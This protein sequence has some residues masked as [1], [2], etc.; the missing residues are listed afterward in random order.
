MDA[1]ACCE[2]SKVLQDGSKCRLVL[3]LD[4]LGRTSLHRDGCIRS[5]HA[6]LSTSVRLHLDKLSELAAL[7]CLDFPVSVAVL[8]SLRHCCRKRWKLISFDAALIV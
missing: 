1:G 7:D 2:M 4:V 6:P 8:S 3:K 5:L